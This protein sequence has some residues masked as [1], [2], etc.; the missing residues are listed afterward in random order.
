[1][2]LEELRQTEPELVAQIEAT[3]QSEATTRAIQEERARLQ[4]IN[5]IAATVGDP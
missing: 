1:M 3:A 4:A 5:E 2:T